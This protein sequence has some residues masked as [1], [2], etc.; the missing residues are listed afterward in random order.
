[1]KEYITDYGKVSP[2]EIIALAEKYLSGD[3][4]VYAVY[5]DRFFC[6]NSI[7]GDIS[8]LMELRIFN[9]NSELKICRYDLS[10]D[11][12]WRYIDDSR[13]IDTI[14]KET[15]GFLRDFNNR[16]FD[17]ISFLDIDSKKSSGKDYVTTGGGKY[18]LPVANAE[19]IKTR[20]YIDYDENGIL[21]INDF[22]IVKILT[23]GE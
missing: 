9:E 13:F 7:E 18:S 12:H 8:H 10:S 6:G 15:D 20:S 21:S 3:C 5:S 2:D 19:R 16:T 17:E 4:I 1:M 22:R 23:K 11:F 14:S